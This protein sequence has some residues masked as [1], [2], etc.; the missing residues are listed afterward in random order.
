MNADLVAERDALAR[1]LAA[2]WDRCAAATTDGTPAETVEEWEAFWERLLRE[3]EAIEDRL[4]AG[5][6]EGDGE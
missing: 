6:G 4:A 3:Y 2:G 5:R 1:R